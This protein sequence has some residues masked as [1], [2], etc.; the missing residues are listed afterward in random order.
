MFMYVDLVLSYAEI[1]YKQS[2]KTNKEA[3]NNDRILLIEKQSKLNIDEIQKNY[4]LSSTGSWIVQFK[5]SKS[6]EQFLIFL[7][8]FNDCPGFL[9]RFEPIVDDPSKEIEEEKDEPYWYRN[10]LG[11]FSP[12]QEYLEYRKPKSDPLIR[13]SKLLNDRL[14]KIVIWNDI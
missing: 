13:Y 1:K 14:N 9:T 7:E 12:P 2:K 8:Y 10:H 6:Q 4:F 11:L 3:I 5:P